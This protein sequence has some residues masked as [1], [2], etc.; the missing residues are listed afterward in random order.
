MAD[1]LSSN[2]YLQYLSALSSAVQLPG[3]PQVIS[4]SQIWDWG[5]TQGSLAG[6][7]FPQWQTLNQVPI[8]PGGDGSTWGSTQG[9]D[10]IYNTWLT[11]AL[12]TTPGVTDP[13]RVQLQ[14]AVNSA[15]GA[16]GTAQQTA[17]TNYKTF[18]QSSK[19]TE[20]YP[21]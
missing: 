13:Q 2:L 17:F 12:D 20:T 10:S 1:N 14:N 3:Q 6:M 16:L 8:S 15:L 5:G 4:P 7:T 21:V 19:S 18:V 9:F 11:V